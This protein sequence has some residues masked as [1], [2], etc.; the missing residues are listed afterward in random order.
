MFYLLNH[1]N[2]ERG[3]T[4][5]QAQKTAKGTEV[6]SVQ[7]NNNRVEAQYP[8]VW[9]RDNCQCPK[10]YQ[11]SALARKLVMKDLDAGISMT[12]P[13]LCPASNEV[14]FKSSLKWLKKENTKI[15]VLRDSHNRFF[16]T[17]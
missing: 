14:F 9:L 8:A 13:K 11:N 16:N 7:W 1:Q 15:G 10:C 6:L 17:V 4:L 5:V 3:S 2:R 12:Q